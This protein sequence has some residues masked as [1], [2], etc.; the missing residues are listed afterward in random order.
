MWAGASV[1]ILQRAVWKEA[2]CSG[3]ERVD[4]P[5]KRGAAG[6]QR[7]PSVQPAA[8]EPQLALVAQ[9]CPVTHTNSCCQERERV[10]F[11]RVSPFAYR[12]CA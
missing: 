12:F 7:P 10:N 8:S 5:R 3:Q 6:P 2:G 1:P 9:P 4:D 11:P